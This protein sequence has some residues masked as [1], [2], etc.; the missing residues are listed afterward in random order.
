[1]WRH[2]IAWMADFFLGVRFTQGPFVKFNWLIWGF[3]AFKEITPVGVEATC[4]ARTSQP[5]NQP[6]RIKGKRK[7]E[8][9]TILTSI[10]MCMLTRFTYTKH[11]CGHKQGVVGKTIQNQT[12]TR[13]TDCD[14]TAVISR[15]F[16]VISGS[17]SHFVGA[18]AENHRSI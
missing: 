2:I 6:N 7:Q 4:R 10:R 16:W 15:D 8:Q 13:S 17:L 9:D 3:C 1:M 14:C 12:P 11:T 5:T 18:I